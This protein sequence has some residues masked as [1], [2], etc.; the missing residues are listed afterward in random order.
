MA[1][2]SGRALGSVYVC[3]DMLLSWLVAGVACL[4][5]C[6]AGAACVCLFL[7]ACEALPFR[8]GWCWRLAGHAGRELESVDCATYLC[9]LMPVRPAGRLVPA[10]VDAVFRAD[11]PLGDRFPSWISFFVGPSR[12]SAFLVES[13]I[14]AQDERW[15]RA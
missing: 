10:G 3:G 11:G 4:G 13:S 12:P 1:W 15:R 6:V 8:W 14:L 2:G 9:L 7:A 5:C